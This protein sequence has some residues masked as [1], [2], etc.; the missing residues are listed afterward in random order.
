MSLKHGLLGLLR[1]SDMTGYELGKAFQDSLCF[2]WQAQSSQIYRELNKLEESGYLSSRIEFQA[3]KPNK[4]IYSITENGKTELTAWLESSM[5]D[6][7]MPTRSEVL[8][9]LFFSA[10]KKPEAAIADL[11][12]IEAAYRIYSAQ[13]EQLGPIIDNY[14]T[15]IQ[16]DVDALYWELTAD[17]GCAYSEM[18]VQWAERCIKRLEEGQP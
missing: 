12:H 4:R 15:L 7:I 8:M 11:K 9:R 6:E 17:F 14:K 2:L 3:D 1:Y 5:P 13:L 18:C 10:A 16:S